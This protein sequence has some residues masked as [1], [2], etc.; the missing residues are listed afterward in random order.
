M[1]DNLRRHLKQNHQKATNARLSTFKFLQTHDPSTVAAIIN[2]MGENIDRAS[3]YRTL[4][5][6][7]QLSIIQDIVVNGKRMIELSD[8]FSIHHHHLS[9]LQCGRHDT[10]SDTTIEARLNYIASLN[11]FKPLSHQIQLSGICSACQNA[12]IS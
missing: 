4:K 2:G 5:L 9:C 3:V 6:F 11:H 7:R 12:D 1:Q 8:N 10:L